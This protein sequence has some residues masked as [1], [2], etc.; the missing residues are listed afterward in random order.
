MAELLLF[1]VWDEFHPVQMMAYALIDAF[2]I[3]DRMDFIEFVEKYGEATTKAA[4][5]LT[6]GRIRSIIKEK[7]TRAAATDGIATLTIDELKC[8]VA[9]V[10]HVLNAFPFS[11][12]E[13][14]ILLLKAWEIVSP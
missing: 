7:I 1:F 2:L 4:L 13:K 6:V 5:V 8:D 14:N 9:S 3:I 10:S 12:E 11:T